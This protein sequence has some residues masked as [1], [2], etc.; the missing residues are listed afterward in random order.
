M[1][2]EYV[3]DV[4]TNSVQMQ[5]IEDE[6]LLLLLFEGQ[7]VE[8]HFLCIEAWKELIQVVFFNEVVF[9][10]KKVEQQQQC[11]TEKSVEV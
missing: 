3:G 11:V 1:G 5:Y 6:V 4:F 2:I 7:N 8:E 9:V 10:I